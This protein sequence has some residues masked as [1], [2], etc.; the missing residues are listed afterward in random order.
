MSGIFISYRRDDSLWC[1]G[2]LFDRLSDTF[3]AGRV[4]IDVESLHPA[5]HFSV[6][7]QRRIESSDI[8]LVLI[9]RDWLSVTDSAGRRR[10]DDPRDLVRA[11]T[12]AALKLDRP[13]IPILIE[14]ARR[15]EPDELPEDIRGLCESTFFELEHAKY[16]SDVERL[17]ALLREKTG[18]DPLVPCRKLAQSMRVVGGPYAVL[19]P[20]VERL[21]PRRALWASAVALASLALSL[22][23]LAYTLTRRSALGEGEQVGRSHEVLRYEESARARM[24]EQFRF[25]GVVT[26]GSTGI[27]GAEVLVENR[28]NGSKA[29]PIRS[30][31]GGKYN[32]DLAELL[33]SPDE[34]V[35]VSV[36]M[37]GYSE[38]VDEFTLKEGFEY[39]SVLV[40]ESARRVA[41][42]T[43]GGS[44]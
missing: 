17:I 6:A 29:K 3:G 11:E 14:G 12:A 41:Y 32:V 10:L 25:K 8:V 4:F 35:R 23:I 19:A 36:R 43:E 38:F 9:G 30:V 27:Q 16:P 37:P 31:H 7:V 13:I 18:S 34:L 5:E 15:P 2:R 1:A 22:H 28:K 40:P 26:D 24:L 44:R 21:G 42:H 20:S 33:S 39:R